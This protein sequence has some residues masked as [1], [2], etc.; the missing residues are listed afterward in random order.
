[1]IRKRNVKART[2]INEFRAI[3]SC[4]SSVTTG[5]FTFYG[6]TALALPSMLALPVC[7]VAERLSQYLVTQID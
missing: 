5:V 3:I 7:L 4:Q 6:L 1:M 2:R